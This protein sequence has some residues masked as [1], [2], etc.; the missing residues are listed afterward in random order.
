MAEDEGTAESL[1]DALFTP[2]PD[3]SLRRLP[4]L[5]W[6]A[7]VLVWRAGRRE[8]LITVGL[9]VVGAGLLGA[10]V[11][12]GRQLLAHL[13]AHSASKN[14]NSAIPV[15]IVLA[16]TLGANAVVTVLRTELQR[17][18]SELVSAFAIGRVL[19]A[20]TAADLLRF[21]DPLFHDRLQRATVNATI[22]PLQMTT[23]LLTVGSS[24][25][26]SLG[27]GVTLIII[28]PLLVALGVVAVVPITLVSLNVGRALYRF[29]ID[30]TPND[31]KRLYIQQLIVGK[32]SAKEIRAYDLNDHL[33]DR[34]KELYA[35]RIR[36][37]RRLVR[38]RIRNGVIGGL[39]TSAITGG[40]L[41]LLLVLVS[42][43]RVSLAGAGA[44]AVALI[45]L[46]T[47]LQSL[48]GGIGSLYESALFI[49]DF[50][51]FVD[52]V[53]IIDRQPVGNPAPPRIGTVKAEGVSFTY[54]SRSEQSLSEVSLTIEPG[55]VVALVGVN[56][57]GKTTLAKLLANL[58][59]PLSGVISWDG[60]DVATLSAD[61][62]RDRVAILFQDFVRYYFSARENITMGRWQ[63]SSETDAFIEAVTLAGARQFLE[64]LPHGYDTLLGPQFF[65]GSDLSGGQWQRMA[66]ARAFYRD[67]ELIILDEPTA[68][69]DP[70]AEAAL[71]ESV[72]KLFAGRS[73]LLI[74][75]R[76]ATVR[77]ADHIY[78]LDGGRVTEHGAHP[79]LMAAGGIY[80][81]LFTL[82]AAA[83]GIGAPVSEP[84]A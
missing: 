77:L 72:R 2:S 35:G 14:F 41:G 74:S 18:L 38:T 12:A 11:L 13:L 75:H 3:R 70:R 60:I 64:G 45:L 28:Q 10:Q 6:G 44:A 76:F 39:L 22:R 27:V 67:A 5:V 36:A 15:L 56:G 62:V 71:F 25:L 57:S 9:Q 78:V 26:A 81:E 1:A 30:Q 16:V 73:V 37:L 8:F 4:A 80:A 21:E 54:P 23:G 33:E 61:G 51:T 83:F 29:A 55:Q 47:Q 66:I 68:A 49:Q 52:L 19:R 63:R 82:Q 31:R 48:A 40:T 7:L 42:A 34:F 32:E 46:G 58:Y 50:N 17:L 59:R 20:A 53:P 69:L 65:G 43:G 79:A 84:T 24:G